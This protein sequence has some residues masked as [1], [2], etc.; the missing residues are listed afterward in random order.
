MLASTAAPTSTDCIS[1]W[2]YDEVQVYAVDVLVSDGEDVR[3]L[4]LSMRKTSVQAAGAAR[5]WLH[6]APFEQGE[7]G[8]DLFR[9]PCLMGLEVASAHERR[10][11]V[12][13][14]MFT[15]GTSGKYL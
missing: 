4:P 13:A 10:N 3:R 8:P 5:R 14:A 9:H 12:S 2:H 7:I 6:L 1:H 11:S 15:P